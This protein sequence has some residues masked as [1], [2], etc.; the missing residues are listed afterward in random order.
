M[1]A[2]ASARAIAI[3]NASSSASALECDEP[4]HATNEDGKGADAGVNGPDDGDADNNAATATANT[5]MHANAAK[6]LHEKVRII[7]EESLRW[8]PEAQIPDLAYSDDDDDE[9]ERARLRRLRAT[10]TAFRRGRP[11]S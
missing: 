3:A 11:S 5:I 6:H 1:G 4:L 2:C 9:D 7:C 10:T 8:Y